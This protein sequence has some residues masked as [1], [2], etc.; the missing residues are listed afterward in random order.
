M[1]ARS[2]AASL[3]LAA[4]SSAAGAAEPLPGLGAEGSTFTVSGISSGGYMAV[5]IHVALSSRVQ[6]A[7]AIAAGPY[8]C[9]QGSIS[10]AMN[11]CM[12]PGSWSPMPSTGVL[13]AHVER[14]AIEKRI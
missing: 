1:R 5:Q 3:L 8:Y 13:K 12:T 7:A 4:L 2:F 14:L 9:A 10:T 11:N 6:G